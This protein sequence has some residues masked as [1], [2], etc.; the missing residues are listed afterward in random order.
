MTKTL[1]LASTALLFTAGAAFAAD[2]SNADKPQVAEAPV[3]TGPT[4]QA[5]LADASQRGV[6]VFTPDFFAAQRPNT[7][8]DMVN[9]VPGFSIDNGSGARGFEGA[10]GNVLINNNRPASKNDSGSN[11]LGR[12]LANQ[13]ERIELIRGGAPGIDMQGYSVVVNVILKTTD[14]RQSILTWNAMLFEG[15]HDIYGG[16]YQFTQNKGDRSWGVTLSDGMGSSDSNGVG[17][18]IR[19]NAAGDVIRDE[20]F[21][22]DGWGGGQ[23]IRGNYTGPVFGGKLEGTARYGLNDYQNWTELSSPTSLRRSDYAED[24]D[25]GELGLTWT[26]TLNPRWTLETRLIHE[27]SSFDSVSGSNETLNGTAAPEQQFKSNGDSSESILRALVRHERSPALTIE[28]GAEIAY[29]MLDVNQAFT[30][31]GVGVPLPSASVKV[32][33]TRGEAFSKAT[34]RINPKLTLEGGVRLEAS[35]I[36]Q[37][38]DADQEKSFFFAKPRLLAT[39]TPMADN[40]LRFRFER[41]LGQLDFGDFAASAE[42]SDGTV[43]GGNVDLEPEQRWI[44]ELSY[45]RRFWGEGVVSIGYRHD[46]IIDVIDRLPLPGGLSATGN[47]G[48][49]TLDQLSL[50]VVVPLDKVGISG[51]RFTFQNDWNKTS[52][53]DPTTG[54]DRRISGVRPS[55]ANVGVQQDITSWKTQWGI[56]WLP[57]L[58]Q[59][60]YDPDQ[61]FAW[62]G[63]DYLEA[64]VE[65]K[66]SPTLSLRAQLNLWDDF[67]Q[68]RT[69]YATRNPRTVAFVEERSIDPRTFVS[70]RVRKTF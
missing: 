29:N 4:N 15:G 50:N 11:V 23:S 54:E 25:S 7:A 52:V 39:W 67:T 37:S 64:F 46:R 45:E 12:T 66:P 63:A 53:T 33:E 57:R 49:G 32:E 16:S 8:L 5:P 14:S 30:I 38:G 35:T 43:F 34:W 10:V 69:V 59:A 36:S 28:A 62:R 9:R 41:E 51:A 44:S 19:R 1:L 22:N 24:G 60:T 42:L 20:R 61:T 65:Y 68:Q 17:R 58:G 47:I 48:D 13:V 6:L 70:L 55:Q 18:S 3:P 56:N 21:E 26:R 27:F 2:A 31:G 40:Q